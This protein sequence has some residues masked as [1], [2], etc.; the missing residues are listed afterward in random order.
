[1]LSGWQVSMKVMLWAELG[2][3]SAGDLIDPESDQWSPGP[4]GSLQLVIRLESNRVT[5]PHH[6]MHQ[7][8]GNKAHRCNQ[9]CEYT[10]TQATTLYYT[11]KRKATWIQLAGTTSM[12]F[13]MIYQLCCLRISSFRDD[14]QGWKIRQSVWRFSDLAWGNDAFPPEM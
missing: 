4:A 9:Q 5:S 6:T 8:T 1:M 12:L 7:F 3:V 2:S 10:S 11:L 14:A 13:Q